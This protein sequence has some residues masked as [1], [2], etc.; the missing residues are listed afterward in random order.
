VEPVPRARGLLAP[1]VTTRSR[2]PPC[3]TSASPPLPRPSPPS[4]CV[5]SA[6]T[7][8]QSIPLPG[9]WTNLLDVSPDASAILASDGTGLFVWTTSNPNWTLVFSGSAYSGSVA[10]GGTHVATTLPDPN[11]GNL[12]TAALW[13]ASTG[14]WTFLPGLIGVSGS[15]LSSSYDISAD[16]SAVVGLGWVTPNTAHAFRWDAVNG[17]VDLGSS[18]GNSSSSRPNC[19]S[20]D[21]SVCAGWDA[22]PVTGAWR[23][24]S[25]SQVNGALLLGSLDPNDPIN[26]WSECW[27]ISADGRYIAGSSGTGLSTPSGWGLEHLFRWDSSNGL[28]DRGTCNVDPF[29]WGSHNTVPTGMSADG[30]VIVGWAG[31]GGPFGS[32]APFVSREGAAMTLLQDDLLALGLPEAS[33]WTFAEATGIS[34]DGRTITGLAY[35]PNFNSFAFRV[36]YPAVSQTYCTAKINSLGCVPTI[37]ASGAASASAFG[38]FTI[39]ASNV[40][41]Q[42][43]GILYYGFGTANLPYQGGTMCISAP[44]VRTPQLQSGGS[45]SGNDCTGTYAMDFNA[46]IQSGV[47]PQL[48][49]GAEIC[50]QF[51]SRD[52]QS[53]S[54]TGLTNAVSFT[55]F[56]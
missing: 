35:D 48:A 7:T 15:S 46:V 45:V 25:W 56:P 47:L 33:T 24:N 26:G 14:Q 8:F 3:A 20:A 37:A 18:G 17:T 51:W 1:T 41:N 6:Q 44:R 42:K 5:S 38:P 10:N 52:P 53:P 16:G 2:S 28:V 4:R 54:T 55:I 11:N 22:D 27:A 21:G 12:E 9:T 49:I 31:G 13:T 39:S 40:L 50:A 43:T 36:T 23:A 29:G 19:V 30:V 32:R 34:A